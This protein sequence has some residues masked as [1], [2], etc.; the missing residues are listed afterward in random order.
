MLMVNSSPGL[1]VVSGAVASVAGISVDGEMAYYRGLSIASSGKGL[2]I[3]TD[4][5]KVERK[6]F[7]L[8]SMQ[9]LG[10]MSWQRAQK[11][12]FPR[13][14]LGYSFGYFSLSSSGAST[15]S[16]ALLGHILAHSPQEMQS[17][18]L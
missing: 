18:A 15:I 5:S 6:T 1:R 8:N 2:I 12:H 10:H 9:F 14:I 11:Q 4:G 17:A 3:V 7:V 16:M 13:S